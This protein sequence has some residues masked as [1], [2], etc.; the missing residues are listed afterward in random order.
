M[1]SIYRLVENFD[2]YFV[3]CV[4]HM[5][6]EICSQVLPKRDI[7]NDS[8]CSRSAEYFSLSRRSLEKSNKKHS[9]RNSMHSTC[10]FIGNVL[11]SIENGFAKKVKKKKN[12]CSWKLFVT[13]R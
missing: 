5:G 3:F 13:S 1:F 10:M 4:L 7:M 9:D 11:I 12:V 8:A 6:K 2:S